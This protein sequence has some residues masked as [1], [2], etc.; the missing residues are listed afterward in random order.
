MPLTLDKYKKNFSVGYNFHRFQTAINVLLGPLL[1]MI[2]PFLFSLFYR[3]LEIGFHFLKGVRCLF[4][5]TPFHSANLRI[6]I[7]FEFIFHKIFRFFSFYFV[8]EKN[9]NENAKKK[10]RF[11]YRENADG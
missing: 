5:K 10:E 8:V 9:E 4:K 11:K 1:K 2:G 7:K 6:A 3:K